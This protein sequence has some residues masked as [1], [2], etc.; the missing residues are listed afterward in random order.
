MA[1]LCT[2]DLP[3]FAQEKPDLGGG[4]C[5]QMLLGD[6]GLDQAALTRKSH[7]LGSEEPGWKMAPD[8]LA[9]VLTQHAGQAF[10]FHPDITADQATRRCAWSILKDG[11]A[12]AV[13]IWK[14]RHWALVTGFEADAVPA[15]ID[16]ANWGLRGFYLRNP[17]GPLDH[18]ID[19][20]SWI[21]QYQTGVLHGIWRTRR[22]VVCTGAAAAAAPELRPEPEPPFVRHALIDPAEIADAASAAVS[23]ERF[24]RHPR[25]RE[26][27]RNTVPG[28][29][30]LVTRLNFP[31]DHYYIVPMRRDGR[32]TLLLTL[33]AYDGSYRE[34]SPVD[35]DHPASPA[36]A[37]AQLDAMLA[38]G[39]VL[40]DDS[41]EPVPLWSD[42]TAVFPSFT[43][44]PCLESLSPYLPFLHV[45]TG[46]RQLHI[47]MD[48]KVFGAISIRF[49]GA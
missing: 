46:N 25:W 1:E 21:A 48:G 10:A 31:A 3:A 18:H 40:V 7:Q 47:R 44:R 35:A 13:L 39:S 22:V 17:Y 37:R 14:C 38:R 49:S 33:D 34:S 15:S 20:R 4:A 6:A 26:A 41:P 36:R 5:V 23:G 42:M 45:N 24:A 27:A 16:A 28:A 19:V 8:A 29:P 43:W 12:P 2:L 9:K 32:A 30:M 11:I